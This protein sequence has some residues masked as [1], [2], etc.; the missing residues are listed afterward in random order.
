MVSMSDNFERS[1]WHYYNHAML[2]TCAPHE[3]VDTSPVYTGEVYKYAGG[4]AT[5]ACPLDFRF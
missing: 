4:G 5:I 3:T 1:A 2:P